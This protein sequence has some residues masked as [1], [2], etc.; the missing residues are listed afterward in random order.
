M[1][2]TIIL[3]MSLVLAGTSNFAQGYKVGDKAA[4]FRLKNVDGKMVSMSDYPD[5][6]GIIVIFTCNHCPYSKLYE[7]RIIAINNKYAVKGY[8]VIAINPND[9]IRQPEDSYSKMIVR[10]KE[11]GFTFPYLL[12]AGQS[13]TRAY[14]ASRTPHVFLL[15]KEGKDYIVRYIGAIDDNSKDPAAVKEKYL[16]NAL[17][18]LLAG[19]KPD[20]DFTKAIGC[21]IKWAEK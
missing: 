12:D 6:K 10:A 17:D 15:Q 5:A 3:I 20:P 18:N 8:P 14:G 1:R 13:I 19:R 11:K 4:D 16:E 2:A 7:D 9:S 21:T